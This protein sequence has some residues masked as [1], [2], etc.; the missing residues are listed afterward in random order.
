MLRSLVGSEMCIRDRVS[1]QSTG[2]STVDM[3]AENDD[4]QLHVVQTMGDNVDEELANTADN[5]S[6]GDKEHDSESNAQLSSWQQWRLI[7]DKNKK[8]LFRDPCSLT[9]ITIAPALIILAISALILLGGDDSYDKSLG[10]A[11]SMRDGTIESALYDKFEDKASLFDSQRDFVGDMLFASTASGFD[12]DATHYLCDYVMNTNNVYSD[13]RT[14]ADN[15]YGTNNPI[16]VMPTTCG[17]TSGKCSCCRNGDACSTSGTGQAQVFSNLND[18]DTRMLD[19]AGTG[20]YLPATIAIVVTSF[21]SSKNTVEWEFYYNRTLV[22][23]TTDQ[24]NDFTFYNSL[25]W[26]TFSGQGYYPVQRYADSYFINLFNG[27]SCSSSS[28]D[29]SGATDKLIP[30]FQSFPFHSWKYNAAKFAFLG[31]LF[32]QFL[33]FC[34]IFTLS[35]MVQ[36]IVDEKRRRIKEGMMMM[37]L[38]NSVFWAS[39]F[40]TYLILFTIVAFLCTVA[41]YVFVFRKSNFGIVFGFLFTYLMSVLGL[42][43][44]ISTLFTDP[45][46]ASITAIFTYLIGIFSPGALTGLSQGGRYVL[47]ILLSPFAF[48]W[49]FGIFG[50]Y[51]GSNQGVTSSTLSDATEQGQSAPI[52]LVYFWAICA[53]DAVMY[54]LLAWYA[55]QVLPGE[56]GAKQSWYFCFLP[57]YWC[58]TGPAEEGEDDKEIEHD[59]DEN[60]ENFQVVSGD[61]EPAVRV[62]N[63]RKVFW[64][65][66]VE[67]IAVH[68]FSVDVYEGQVTA[69]LGHNGAGKST[70][71]NMLSGLMAPTSGDATV[72]GKS[73]RNDL[74]TVRKNLGVC[75]QHDV[76]WDQLTVLEHLQLFAALKGVPP[77]LIDELAY[78]VI[79][80]VGLTEKTQQYSVTLSGGQKRKLSIGIAT[81]GNSKVVY[82]DEPTSGMDPFSRRATWEVI[83]A[84][85]PGHVIIFTTHFMDEAD[86]LGDRIAIMS[87]GKLSCC[88]DSLFLKKRFGLG[89]HLT[90]SKHVGISKQENDLLTG[91]VQ[92]TVA[93][94]V[95]QLDL[96]RDCQLA[97]AEMAFQL[98]KGDNADEESMLRESFINLFGQLDEMKKEHAA[99][100]DSWG[101]SMTTLEEVFLKLAADSHA[102]NPA[103]RRNTQQSIRENAELRTSFSAEDS[104]ERRA[105]T[106]VSIGKRTPGGTGMATHFT[107]IFKKRLQSAV[108]D[109]FNLAIQTFVPLVFIVLALIAI[110]FGLDLSADSFALTADQFN[111]PLYVPYYCKGSTDATC[112]GTDDSGT[113]Q[114]QYLP[115][116]TGM[117]GETTVKPLVVNDQ[118]S[119]STSFDCSNY[120]NTTSYGYPY[121]SANNPQLAVEDINGYY[122]GNSYDYT[123]SSE[124]AEL[125]SG[126]TDATIS[127]LYKCTSQ[128]G[129]SD[130]TLMGNYLYDNRDS[131]G[132][133]SKKESKYGAMSF[134]YDSAATG[135]MAQYPYVAQT[136]GSA[137]NGPMTYA[138]FANNLILRKVTNYAQ[139]T[140]SIKVSMT[141]GPW[142]SSEEGSAKEIG[143]FVLAFFLI[144]AFSIVPAAFVYTL[145]SE[146][147]VKAKH[148]QMISGTKPAAYW[149]GTFAWDYIFYNVPMW[150]TIGLILAFTQEQ[151]YKSDQFPALIMIFFLYGLASLP[152]TYCMSF[153]FK[154]ENTALIYT[155]FTYAISGFLL[156]LISFF[157][158][159][160][161]STQDFNDKLRYL[162]YFVPQFSFA[163]AIYNL[164]QYYYNPAF[165]GAVCK[166]TYSS[167]WDIGV[168][169]A[170]LIYLG[171]MSAVFTVLTLVLQAATTSMDGWLTKVF[172]QSPSVP[173]E[174][175]D[176]DMDE[177]VFAEAERVRQLGDL[178]VL[179]Q[180]YMD[181]HPIIVKNLRKVYH[182]RGNISSKVA[183]RNVSF[184]V[185][186]GE[187]FAY[188]GIN[189]AG[190]TTSISMMA[191]EFP[192]TSGQGKLAGLDMRRDREEIN[193]SMGYCPQFDALFPKLTA[194]EHLQ[195]YARI[196]GI[197]VDQERAVVD[198]LI[199]MMNLTDHCEREAGGYSGGN[200]RK[201]SVAIALLGGPKIVFLDEPSTGMDPEARRFMWKVIASTMAGRCVILTT[202]SMEEAEALSHKITIMV[203]GRLRCIGTNQHLKDKFGKGYSL[204]IRVP[205]SENLSVQ[206]WINTTFPS[207][208]LTE[209]LGS[210]LRYEIPM[211]GLELSNAWETVEQGKREHGVTEYAIS[212]TT[213]E[214]V[215][216]RFA[217]EQE[218][219][220]GL[221]GATL[222]A[223]VRQTIPNCFD[224]CICKPD[225]VHTWKVAMDHE[226]NEHAEVKVEFEFG[227]CLCC[228]SNPGVVTVNGER[229][230]KLDGDYQETNEYLEL[231]ERANPGCAESGCCGCPSCCGMSD[232]FCCRSTEQLF[233]HNGKLFEVIDYNEIPGTGRARP[234]FLMVDGRDA[235]SKIPRSTFMAAV[236][237]KAGRKYCCIVGIPLAILFVLGLALLNAKVYLVG[238]VTL[239]ISVPLLIWFCTF[240]ICGNWCGRAGHYRNALT[241]TMEGSYAP[242]IESCQLRTQP[243]KVA[244]FSEESGGDLR[245]SHELHASLDTEEIIATEEVVIA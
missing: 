226:G 191:G 26:S 217:S 196:K 193:K 106:D 42:G 229:V 38:K 34:L 76:L 149:L 107:A 99:L 102:H 36:S 31:S 167:P 165:N 135:K 20:S 239:A 211:E 54:L 194:R 50:T 13:A 48:Y 206:T 131:D 186:V 215:F 96:E 139:S 228:Q 18:L 9:C 222:R 183:V 35:Y 214:Q 184:Q 126:C 19:L 2:I 15:V 158:G 168:T 85:R 230:R 47:C 218:E 192:P 49:G 156:F 113:D 241:P 233:I 75:P 159:V 161:S 43:M 83:K 163:Q 174:P 223:A 81:I 112:P 41:A 14:Y 175:D 171:V 176:P 216:V 200:K 177:D 87:E 143:G 63:L 231:I 145:V 209:N 110:K 132:Y 245:L 188:L 153:F 212:Q 64:S 198:N 182:G 32:Q 98:P 108:R 61:T 123:I 65:N 17:S 94:C 220:T 155:V 101:I 93:A 103:H 5:A 91:K 27:I 89:Y 210:Q 207:S 71:F 55:D 78:D 114:I 160:I 104:M 86:L 227:A 189:G 56:F 166:C 8:L 3:A 33:G 23:D 185:P 100:L 122:N 181:N 46:T 243:D 147:R 219:E 195:M 224:M 77:H 40:C 213:L 29:C 142:T 119:I 80:A 58:G 25:Y 169:G 44:L 151:F 68:N 204:E 84:H 1:T 140:A 152:Q 120:Q 136:N 72:Y 129:T 82:L 70:T 202:H 125:G 234:C 162:L 117:G 237:E 118:T 6:G 146:V 37:G 124:C 109:K 45:G 57:S 60:P 30:Y 7:M 116:S 95:P 105:T 88:G 22:T 201:L 244:S 59:E 74:H 242:V 170:P 221:D 115:G 137:Y 178:E 134:Y 128:T 199:E 73:I 11:G 205:D 10:I 225:K 190:K 39:W 164:Q 180:D 148:Q 79:A 67:K 24:T 235:E 203:G 179:T 208:V 232:C 238:A 52:K 154:D 4:Q 69:L 127:D 157:L 66:G 130:M 51:E 172:H 150:L 236:F 16:E 138:N 133:Y 62:R 21:D 187:V 53:G 197:A 173:D 28:F 12:I 111:S 121:G 144:I 90:V 240:C 141:P 97:G 92:Q